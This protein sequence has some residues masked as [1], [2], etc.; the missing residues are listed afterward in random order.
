MKI[1][2]ITAEYDPFHNGHAYH[3]R[4]AKLRSGC[5]SLIVLMSG[6]FTQR[7]TPAIMDKYDRVEAALKNGADVV[8]ELPVY[9][10][11]ASAEGFAEGAMRA[12]AALGVDTVS[13]GIECPEETEASFQKTRESL[14][15]AASFF[16]FESEE[17]QALLKRRLA[18]GI[19]YASARWGAFTELSE[20]AAACPVS[21]NNTLA[22]EYEKA[23]L[24]EN[25]PLE[26][27]PVA[28]TGSGY[29]DLTPGIYASAT[30]IRE[31]ILSGKI[32]EESV[33]ESCL[34]R[35]RTLLPHAVTADDLSDALYAVLSLNSRTELTKYG[36][37]TEDFA[38]RLLGVLDAP[39]LWSELAAKLK[40]RSHALSYVNR[41]LCHILLD[42]RK[43]DLASFRESLPYLHVLGIRSGAESVLSELSKSSSV[44]LLVRLL[45]DSAALPKEASRLFQ[46]ELRATAL[47]N[48][49][50]YQKGY[51]AVPELQ[52]RFTVV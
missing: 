38:G 36:D 46:K 3:I 44:P 17:Y 12:M 29:H 19:S 6:D 20:D 8:I 40:E 37:I 31:Q 30:A 34:S 23:V 51:R 28:R 41:A 32:P 9:C 21:P 24:K 7:G 25:L 18:E 10:A 22:I 45:R 50:L 1:L 42:I 39:F 2:G 14:H 35:Y 49:L 26:L 33:P 47:Y 15:H 13:Y 48:Q 27:L 16:A 4:E 11:T 43:D 5:D 52:R